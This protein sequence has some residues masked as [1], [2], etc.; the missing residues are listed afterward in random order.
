MDGMAPEMLKKMV[1][2]A[3]L[4]VVMDKA[5]RAKLKDRQDHKKKNNPETNPAR[6]ASPRAFESE[7]DIL[8]TISDAIAEARAEVS[9]GSASTKTAAAPRTKPAAP[10]PGRSA[11]KTAS[12]ERQALIR[13]AL[14]IHQQKQ[15]V[16]DALP[17]EVREKLMIMAM[18]AIDPDALAPE[19]RR[20]AEAENALENSNANGLV[21]DIGGDAPR[22]RKR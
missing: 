6:A 15:E 19:A 22:R 3:L 1:S 9:G 20:I 18:Y 8:S 7:D 13:Q 11:P 14:A 17:K 16:L 4:S 2:D 5:A 21:D 10:A 12:P